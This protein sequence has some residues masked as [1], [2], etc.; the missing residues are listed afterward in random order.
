MTRRQV[1]WTAT[2]RVD[3]NHIVSFIAE[4]DI[5]GALAV[6]GRIQGR[7][8]TLGQRPERGR[9][10]PELRAID[11]LAY[12]ELIEGRWRIVYRYDR[13]NVFIA[14]V[15]DGRRDLSSLLLERL[16]R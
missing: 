5:A 7:C 2:A 11:V 6:A 10:V 1:L 3:L 13:R 12:R 9:V 14:A 15:L 4:D 16:V 8:E